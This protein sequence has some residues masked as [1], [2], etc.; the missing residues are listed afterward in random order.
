MQPV[1]RQ[2]KLTLPTEHAW[3]GYKS[4]VVVATAVPGHQPGMWSQADHEQARISIGTNW[5]GKQWNYYM[6]TY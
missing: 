4:G 5:T 2:D 1:H 3:K 6:E